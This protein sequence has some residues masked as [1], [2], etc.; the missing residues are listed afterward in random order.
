MA[1]REIQ[2][3]ENA[4]ALNEA[5]AELFIRIAQEAIDQH[6]WFSVALSGGSTPRSLYSLLASESYSSAID[7]SRVSFF[8]GDERNVPPD[9]DESNY[10]MAHETL[11]GPLGI[12]AKQVHRWRTELPDIDDAARSYEADLRNYLDRSKRGLDLVLLGLGDDAHT[13]SLFP[14]SPALREKERLAVVNPVEKLHA[15]RLTMTFP[16]INS[17]VNIMFLVSGKGKSEAVASVLEAEHNPDQY[18]A[19]SVQPD[20]G[21]LYWLVDKD[22]AADLKSK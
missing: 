17:A 9:S 1:T 19:Q 22:A 3:K 18:P 13:A 6:K 10:R 21:R 11:L 14:H 5:A 20:N 4:A 12:N 8:F 15:D 2:I 7:W 16:A